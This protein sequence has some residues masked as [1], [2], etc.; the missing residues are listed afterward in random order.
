VIAFAPSGPPVGMDS[1][2]PSVAYAHRAIAAGKGDV[3]VD[4]GN[5]IN[6]ILSTPN[7]YLSWTG[8]E[9]P[10]Y[11]IELLPRLT[12][13][14]LWVAG[15]RDPGQANAAERYAHAPANGSNAFVTVDADHFGT[16]DAAVQQM[17]DWLDRLPAPRGR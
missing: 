8:M 4:F 11:D 10:L 12:A 15:T 7:D 16:P 9:S 1:N 3:V 5:G 2:N 13:P 17:I 6:P 14:L